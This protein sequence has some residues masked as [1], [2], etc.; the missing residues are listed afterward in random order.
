[1]REGLHG[2]F[3]TG[4]LRKLHTTQFN[5]PKQDALFKKL[6]RPFYSS[7]L[8]YLAMNAREAGGDLVLIQTSKLLLCKCQLISIRTT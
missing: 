6:D 4:I 7:V 2:L 8:S 3:C 1:M 5:K